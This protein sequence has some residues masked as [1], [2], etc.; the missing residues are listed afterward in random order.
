MGHSFYILLIFLLTTISCKSQ[1]LTEKSAY[2]K[3]VGDIAHDKTLDK[4]EFYLC[5]AEN[6]IQYHNDYQ[7]LQYKGEK[8]ALVNTFSKKYVPTNQ[9]EDSGLIRIRFVVNC[10]GETD[11]FRLIAMDN[12][13]KGKNFGK[14]VTR[15][16]ISICKS[17]DGW[18]PKKLDGRAVDYYQYLI[19]KIKNGQIIEIMP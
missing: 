6:I 13:Y 19:F 11:R 1:Q 12:D 8:I 17:L 4:K 3:S 5:D 14:K 18:I 16:L 15:Q 2:I 10:K 7:G 9:E